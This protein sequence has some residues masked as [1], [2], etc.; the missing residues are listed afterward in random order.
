MQGSPNAYS[1]RTG[2]DSPHVRVCVDCDKR[3]HSVTHYSRETRYCG[4]CGLPLLETLATSVARV[5]PGSDTY[6]VRRFG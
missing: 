6:W 4:D 2:P 1:A 5:S 3:W